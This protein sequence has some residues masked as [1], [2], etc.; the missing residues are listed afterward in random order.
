MHTLSIFGHKSEMAGQIWL[1]FFTGFEPRFQVTADILIIID[2]QTCFHS[3]SKIV[4][5]VL[6][7]ISVAKA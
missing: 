3:D 1:F 5:I 6:S 4:L 2:Q 7:H